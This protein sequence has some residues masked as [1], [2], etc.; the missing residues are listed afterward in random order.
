MSDER[1]ET[2]LNFLGKYLSASN[3]IA[4]QRSTRLLVAPASGDKLALA[5]KPVVDFFE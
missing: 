5:F 3:S 1:I 4:K 2:V